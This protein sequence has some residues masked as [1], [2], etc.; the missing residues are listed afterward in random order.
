MQKTDLKKEQV[1]FL[2]TKAGLTV[3][4]VIVVAVIF[5][6]GSEYRAYR[7][8]QSISAVF[9]TANEEPAANKNVIES[10]IG[11]P[12]QLA[13][14]TIKINS[15]EEKQSL[16]STYGSA[17]VAKANTKFVVVNLDVTNTTTDKIT[18][19]ASTID[20]RDNQ[21]RTFETYDDTIGNVDNYLEMRDLSPSITE[22][23]VLVFELPSDATSYAFEIDKAGTGD[24]YMVKLK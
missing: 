12:F 5:I 1:P 15:S 3:I 2:K 7:V 6:A 13:M 11:E 23:G 4:G 24:R 22:N 10:K 21:G 9:D 19:S 17:V 14:G 20:L 16:A 8:R 18:F